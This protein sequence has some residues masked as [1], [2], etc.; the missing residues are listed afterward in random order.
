M[1]NYN[2]LAQNYNKT[3]AMHGLTERNE[4]T[5]DTKVNINAPRS[6]T[7]TINGNGVLKTPKDISKNIIGYKKPTKI[8]KNSLI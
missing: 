7:N 6:S 4:V 3:I 2:S 8:P 5:R 1:L